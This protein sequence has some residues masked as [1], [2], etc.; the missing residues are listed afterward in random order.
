[1]NS[2]NLWEGGCAW[3]IFKKSDTSW[4]SGPIQI[5]YTALVCRERVRITQEKK[6]GKKKSTTMCLLRLTWTACSPFDFNGR[7]LLE[8]CVHE[9]LK[10]SVKQARDVHPKSAKRGFYQRSHKCFPFKWKKHFFLPRQDQ[11]REKLWFLVYTLWKLIKKHFFTF[12][13]ASLFHHCDLFPIEE[14]NVSENCHCCYM[15]LFNNLRYPVFA[16]EKFITFQMRI[17]K[18]AIRI[19]ESLISKM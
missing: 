15:F 5:Y 13:T 19:M 16:Y 12:T 6:E 4:Q 8:T 14:D 9:T 11:I 7:T 2:G 18:K 1:M 3:K 10:S 17:F